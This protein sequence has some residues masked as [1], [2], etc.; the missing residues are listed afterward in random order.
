MKHTDIK[1]G[2][3]VLYCYDMNRHSN[4][5]SA[6]EIKKSRVENVTR[7]FIV[8]NRG[9]K[10]LREDGKLAD[11]V[12]GNY[13]GQLFTDEESAREFN[14]RRIMHGKLFSTQLHKLADLNNS[15]LAIIIEIM[16]R[17]NLIKA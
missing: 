10:F 5:H 14:E 1:I 17:N 12:N 6:L 4:M 7:K 15:D 13:I 3:E 2:D 16:E 9:Q 11:S 8:I